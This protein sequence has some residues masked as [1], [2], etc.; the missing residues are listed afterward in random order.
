MLSQTETVR[1]VVSSKNY[2]KIMKLANL[3]IEVSFD[4]ALT[5][6]LDK[7]TKNEFYKKNHGDLKK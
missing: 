3:P 5:I 4:K 2:K 1:A 6:T 7:F